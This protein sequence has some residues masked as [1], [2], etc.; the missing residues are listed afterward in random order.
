MKPHKLQL[1]K[2]YLYTLYLYCFLNVMLYSLMNQYNADAN[3]FIYLLRST[4]SEWLIY[5]N[6]VN[7]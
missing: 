3:V 2:P 5:L 1:N 4:Y 7:P 6:M